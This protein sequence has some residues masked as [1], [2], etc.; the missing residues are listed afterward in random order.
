MSID[1][2]VHKEDVVLIHYGIL[3]SHKRNEIMAFAATWIHPEIIILNEVRQQD[4]N[5]ICYHLYME[6]K[7]RIQ[8]TYL[9]NRNWLT[10]F[11]R[12]MVTKGDML[13]GGSDGLGVW[14]W[15]V[16]NLGCDDG[17]TT[18]NIIN[19]LSLKNK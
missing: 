12:L 3:L 10:D 18:M 4:R 6:S 7:K 16:V 11:E 8:W 9:Q 17:R 1:R 13:W 14:A 5:I 19:S 2:G 15:N